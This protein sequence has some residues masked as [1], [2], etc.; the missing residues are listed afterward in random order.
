MV[1]GNSVDL[2]ET[3][4]TVIGKWNA[5]LVECFLNPLVRAIS[6]IGKVALFSE[7]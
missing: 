7:A 5:S 6:A 1:D 4:L 2:I 3:K